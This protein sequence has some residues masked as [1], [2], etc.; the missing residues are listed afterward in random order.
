M[1]VLAMAYMMPPL[2]PSGRFTVPLKPHARYAPAVAPGIHGLDGLGWV[3]WT[4]SVGGYGGN[5][6]LDGWPYG[7]A[8]RGL[9][10]LPWGLGHLP[11]GL[12]QWEA[13]IPLIT[14]AL[15]SAASQ[16]GGGGPSGTPLPPAYGMT[17]SSATTFQSVVQVP[18]QTQA[19]NVQ[20]GGTSGQGGITA[21]FQGPDVSA[22][23]Q[24]GQGGIPQSGMPTYGSMAPETVH[25]PMQALTLAPQAPA[26]DILGVPMWAWALGAVG[27]VA[28]FAFMAPRRAGLGGRRYRRR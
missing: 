12:G 2:Y 9:G 13:A 22:S 17:P 14:G 27:V 28:L 3:H 16:K 25:Q 7:P 4:Y 8:E 11:W 21:P 26:G 5:R 24:F 20:V 10:H 18:V 23:P 19:V 15:S 6:R 1:V